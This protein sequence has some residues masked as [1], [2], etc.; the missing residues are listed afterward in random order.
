MEKLK[1]N[2]GFIIV[3]S[4]ITL[5][6]MIAGIILWQQLPEQMATTWGTDNIPNGWSSKGFAVFGLPVFCLVVHLFC[7]LAT[8]LDPKQKGIGGKI[9]KLI[10]LICPVVSLLCGVTIYSY[11][12]SLDINVELGIELLVGLMFVI[13]GNYLPK[14]RQNYTVGIK[15]PWTLEDGENWNHTHRLAGWIWIPCGLFFM[16]N[17]FL[18]IGGAWIF[19]V[20]F[21]VMVLAPVGYSFLYYLRHK[22]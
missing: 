19:F 22:K 5:V 20:V 11:A 4:L 21:A 18:S 6:P 12:L 8:V 9:F 13:F 14:C 17:A 15:L 7:T 1:E 16:V 3:T 2:R 10:L